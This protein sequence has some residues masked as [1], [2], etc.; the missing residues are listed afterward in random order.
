MASRKKL[1]VSPD[2]PVKRAA[3]KLAD[4][5]VTAPAPEKPDWRQDPNLRAF[6]CLLAFET[7]WMTEPENIA[8]LYDDARKVVRVQRPQ[9]ST[10]LFGQTEASPNMNAP[11]AILEVQRRWGDAV[12]A[13]VERYVFP[14]SDPPGE[15]TGPSPAARFL[16]SIARVCV[17]EGATEERIGM[18]LADVVRHCVSLA[19]SA[20]IVDQSPSAAFTRQVTVGLLLDLISPKGTG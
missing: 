10:T 2:P 12:R 6:A 19:R 18:A 16:L 7:G 17:A 8:W 15:Q 3:P 1:Q 5:P 14:A 11:Q 13:K 20:N 4:E 9:G